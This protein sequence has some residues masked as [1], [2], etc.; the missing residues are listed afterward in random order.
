MKKPAEVIITPITNGSY[1]IRIED[2]DGVKEV[3]LS[4]YEFAK[5]IT[6][7]LAKGESIK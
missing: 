6:G 3:I 5:V 7:K 2:E 4:P 1:M